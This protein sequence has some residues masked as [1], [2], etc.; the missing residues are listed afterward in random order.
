MSLMGRRNDVNYVVARTFYLIAGRLLDVKI[1]VEGEEHIRNVGSAVYIGNHQS[2]LDLFFLGA[3]FPKQCSI[4]A[5]K[6][7][8]WLPILGQWMTLSGAVFVDRSSNTNAIRSLAEA[9]AKMKQNGTSIW[10]FPEGTR[11]M[12][13]KAAMKPFKKGAFH[14]ALQS[15]I[16]IVPVVFENYWRMYHPGIFGGGTFRIKI[17][18]PVKT[19]GYQASD[20]GELAVRLHASMLETL[21]EISGERSDGPQS[22]SAPTPKAST[23]APAGPS[24]VVPPS[25]TSSVDGLSQRRANNNGNSTD[26][27]ATEEDEGMVLVGRP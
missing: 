26:G 13:Q 9:G 4:M 15:G 7:L 25:G 5:K 1:E 23:P 6:E 10:L 18:P 11:T 27:H 8:Q 19:E 2:M 20:V 16:P 12:S 24:T 14:L 17:L 3:M 21:Q 22:D